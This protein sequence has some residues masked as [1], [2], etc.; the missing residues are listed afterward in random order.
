MYLSILYYIIINT[1]IYTI[2]EYL[3]M[4]DIV[5]VTSDLAGLLLIADNNNI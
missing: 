4:Y 2:I 3:Y 1:I 5:T